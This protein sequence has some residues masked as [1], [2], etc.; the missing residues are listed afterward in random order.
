MTD[1]FLSRLLLAIHGLAD[2]DLRTPESGG[3]WSIFD[4]IAHLADFEGVVNTRL[5]LAL[6]HDAPPFPSFD[7]EAFV[8]SHRGEPLAPLLEQLGFFRRMNHSLLARVTPTQRGRTGIHPSFGPLTITDV[9]ARAQ[10][11]AERH[12]LQIERIRDAHGLA[13][14]QSSQL[15]GMQSGHARNAAVRTFGDV[16]VRD[17]WQNGVKRALQVDF[18]PGAQWPG[19]D[20]HVP[21]P[22]EV[23][24]VTGDFEDAGTVYGPGTFLHYPAG[25]SHSPRSTGGCRLF[26]FYPEG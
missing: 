7:Q 4:V 19:L 3:K 1:D 14:S 21:G 10:K 24:V 8:L 11:H 25:S 22:E 9:E 17:L 23:F 15:A 2:D 26:V 5:K 12:L 20:H 6:A 13:P 18:P 16:Q